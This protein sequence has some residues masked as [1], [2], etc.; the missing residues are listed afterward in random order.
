[1]NTLNGGRLDC[2]GTNR[3]HPLKN[4][5]LRAVEYCSKEMDRQAG[6]GDWGAL[7][8]IFKL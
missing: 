6:D 4:H 2:R 5:C 7:T 1:M 3:I 8:I